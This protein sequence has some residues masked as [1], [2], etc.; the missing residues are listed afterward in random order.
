MSRIRPPKINL[1]EWGEMGGADWASSMTDALESLSRNIG[2]NSNK[3]LLR[4]DEISRLCR[5]GT[6]LSR[7][8]KTKR[9]A[10][11]FAILWNE[12]RAILQA[13]PP[14]SK[15]LEII[16]NLFPRPSLQIVINLLDLFFREYDHL[17]DS[18]SL[19]QTVRKMMENYSQSPFVGDQGRIFDN[20][21]ILFGPDG[22]RAL[23]RES[24]RSKKDFEQA[25]F[26][27]GL[28][29]GMGGRF[30]ELAKQQYYLETIANLKIGAKS[31]I[32]S[33]VNK[34]S[35][36]ESPS[37]RNGEFFGHDIVR[38]MIDR[39]SASKTVMPD[40][41][42]Q[43]VLSI[44]GDPRRSKGGGNYQRWWSPLEGEYRSRMLRW[45]SRYDLNLFLRVLQESS[46]T[47]AM[48]R[49]FPARR[50]FLEG[51]EKS[52]LVCESV[53]FLS[54]SAESYVKR[55]IP[56][57]KLPHYNSLSDYDTSVIYL[58]LGKCHLIEGTHNYRLW[59][60]GKLPPKNPIDFPFFSGLSSRDLGMG[61]KEQYE[62]AIR[63]G[64]QGPPPIGVIHSRNLTWQKNA[65]KGMKK[66]GLRVDP[67]KVLSAQDYDEYLEK[68]G[69]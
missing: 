21:E 15:T 12:D 52:G 18:Q 60:H 29:I 31:A 64:K 1:P 33:E 50:L 19:S 39:V 66:F 69:A 51:L 68:F 41:W 55:S 20:K 63:T 37:Q 27:K 57:S 16:H 40:N 25:C 36:K 14:S 54:W 49:M 45:L 32:F 43:V 10:K 67:E 26:D 2:T 28:P 34:T 9:D 5:K 44:A 17:P 48:K 7:M 56:K 8:L 58:N 3:F 38:A 11:I 35:V 4:K 46:T 61:L 59:L 13:Y 22:P 65:I 30:L 47:D 6:P 62:K 23:A 42:I 53:L 24:I